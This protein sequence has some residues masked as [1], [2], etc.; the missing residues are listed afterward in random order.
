MPR[1][2][3]GSVRRLPSGRYQASYWHLAERHTA[4]Q[5]FETKADAQSW[6]SEVETEIRRGRWINPSSGRLLF[7]AYVDDWLTQR[8]D[9]RP[10][11]RELYGSLIKRHLKPTFERV[12]LTDITTASIRRWHAAIAKDQPTTAAKAYRLLRTVLMTAVADGLILANPCMVKGAGQERAPERKVPSLET[13]EAIATGV[14]DRYQA[15]VYTAA[16]AGL[17]AGEL[18]GLERRHIDLVHRIIT[19]EQQAQVIVGQ[20]RVLGPTKSDA[21]RRTVAIPSELVRILDHHVATY[22]SPEPDAVV[23]TGEKNAPITTQH[24]SK[25]FREAAD[26]AGATDLHFHDLRH[27]AGTLAAATGASTRELMARL[28][29]S[30]PRASLIYQHATEKR[31]RAIATGIDA[32]LEAAKKESREPKAAIVD[33]ERSRTNRARRPRDT[34]K[35]PS[36]EGAL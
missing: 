32:I 11:T 18:S 34:K 8:Y 5:T 28:G 26:A 10:R 24:W 13:V 7:G 22:V 21:G 25:R 12:P 20:G 17:R 33:L 16:L 4:D 31:D 15:L 3:F 30:T 6:L 1:R 14:G 36:E 35:A 23:F 2:H 29:H 27:F 19:V 9:I